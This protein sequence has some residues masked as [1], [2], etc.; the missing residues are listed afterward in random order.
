MKVYN[1][2][3]HN[4]QKL[5]ATKMTFNRCTDKHTVVHTYDRMLFNKTK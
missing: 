4:C 3:I 1:S 2:F 5:E